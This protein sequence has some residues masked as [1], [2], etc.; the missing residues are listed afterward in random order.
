MFAVQLA[1]YLV[2]CA[3]VGR[4]L[5][6]VFD[7]P[8]LGV[9]AYAVG[10]LNPILLLHVSE[11][12]SDLLSAVLILVSVALAWKAPG[13][14]A[15][16]SP[17]RQIFLS[18]FFAAAAVAVRPANIVVVVAL[19]LVWAVRARAGATSASREPVRRSPGS[20]RHSF[21]RSSS[22]TGCSGR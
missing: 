21:R 12:L 13:R 1:V 22:T 11:T 7:S 2:A 9:L 15:P 8:G 17:T 16:R 10:A 14:G 3:Y 19:V 20:F 4:R 5:A 6:D 18:F